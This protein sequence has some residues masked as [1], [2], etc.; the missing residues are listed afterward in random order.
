M[1]AQ[2]GC[3]KRDRF[4]RWMANLKTSPPKRNISVGWYPG[5]SHT[6]LTLCLHHLSTSAVRGCQII[7]RKKTQK[8]LP[9]RKN[10]PGHCTVT[11]L[12]PG[13][14][15]VDSPSATGKPLSVF[16]RGHS[17]RSHLLGRRMDFSRISKKIRA[18]FIYPQKYFTLF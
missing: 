1:E 15:P 11:D 16:S 3:Q 10:A 2:E 4:Q 17:P 5:N 14:L 6:Y 18:S 12:S 13:H 9:F 7:R 8:F